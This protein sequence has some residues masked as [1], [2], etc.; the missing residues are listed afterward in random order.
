MQE[1]K[2]SLKDLNVQGKRVLI[3]VDFNVPLDKKGNITDDSR[4]KASLPSIR[5]VIDH[6]GSVILMSHLGRPKG[7]TPE[8]SLAPC[9]KQLSELLKRPVKMASDCVGE[10]VEKMTSSLKP[11]EVILLENLR[12]HKGEEHPDDEPDFV[13]K[14]AKLGDLYVND[15]FGT[16][17]RAH[18]STALITKFFPDLS[19]A[20]FLLEKEINYL[21]QTLLKPHR[22]F[23][24]II[25]GAKISTKIGVI[26]SLL[27]KADGLFIGGG[28]AYTFFKAKG[29]PIGDSIHED[30]QLQEAKEIL[31]LTSAGRIKFFLPSDILIADKIEE[32]AH[33]QLIEASKG[34]PEGWQGVDIGPKTIDIF[35]RELQKAATILWN[36][37]LGIFEIPIFAKGTHAIAKC[38]AGLSATTIVGGGDSIAALQETGVIDKI[39]HVSTGGGATL[40]YIEFGKLPGIEALT[41]KKVHY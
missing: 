1:Q 29:I 12:F 40:E 37:P 31:E 26:K 30:E 20:G 32:D 34:I 39:S 8:L 22:P 6:G 7:I 28:M 21:G 4:I 14:L 11:G 25:G 41:N 5:Y 38:L 16:A 18:A 13:Q 9:A 10:A 3:R 17:H 35:S 2:L 33:T 27:K 24:A 19:A 36:G 23:Y 15:A